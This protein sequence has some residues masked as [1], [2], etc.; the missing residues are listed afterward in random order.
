MDPWLA[1]VGIIVAAIFGVRLF[2]FIIEYFGK[3]IWDLSGM[4]IFWTFF[5]GIILIVGKTGII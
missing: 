1:I 3:I 4:I 5:I 2:W